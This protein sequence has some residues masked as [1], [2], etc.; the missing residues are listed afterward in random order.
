MKV[1]DISRTTY[2][3]L[4]TLRHG[5][6]PFC[7]D[8]GSD[9]FSAVSGHHDGGLRCWDLRTG[10]RTS[11][12]K[13]RWRDDLTCHYRI[14]SNLIY[15]F[16]L[17][18]ALE[19]HE[20]G[21]TSVHFSPVDATKVLTNGMDSTLRVIDLRKGAP[22]ETFRDT[23]LTTVQ[24]WSRAVWSPNGRYVAAGANATGVLL[25]W[26]VH[27]GALTKV[28]TNPTPQSSSAKNNSDKAAAATVHTGICG[29]D[30]GRGGSSG[31]QVATLDR[32]GK[33]ILWA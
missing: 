26:N 29:V 7:V 1:W 33:L 22:V 15:T 21:I 20:G 12:C 2:K 27:T 11:D 4:V 24:T 13:G 32:R 3:Q 30:W 6:T 18:A 9:S 28:S 16:L 10:D 31:Q 8:V 23:D 14:H 19:M 17:F 5:S 25:V